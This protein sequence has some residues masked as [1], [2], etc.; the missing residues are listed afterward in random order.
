MNISDWESFTCFLANDV[1]ETT[2]NLHHTKYWE[3][4]PVNAPVLVTY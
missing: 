2:P 4:P 3:M 1:T